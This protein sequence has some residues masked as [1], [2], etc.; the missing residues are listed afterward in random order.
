MKCPDCNRKMEFKDVDDDLLLRYQCEC[1]A[2]WK[3]DIL[4][5]PE[6][7]EDD[8]KRTHELIKKYGWKV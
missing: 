5:P 7:T 4:A 3:V 1:G 2:A 6:L 8:I